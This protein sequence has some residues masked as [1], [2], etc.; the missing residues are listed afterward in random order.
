MK[1]DLGGHCSFQ[2]NMLQNKPVTAAIF[3]SLFCDLDFEKCARFM[4]AKALGQNEVPPD[5]YPNHTDRLR[6]IMNN[7]QTG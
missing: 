7:N 5:L 3:K 1:C 4:A 6:R 2:E